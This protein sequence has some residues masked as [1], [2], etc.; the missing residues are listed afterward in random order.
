MKL[1]V[2]ERRELA[3]AAECDD[4]TIRKWAAGSKVMK[5]S[6]KERIDRAWRAR[7]K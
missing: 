6:V 1:T 5:P 3:A 2:Q 7:K 4:R